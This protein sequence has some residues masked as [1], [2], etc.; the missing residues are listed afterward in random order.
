MAAG[1][2][3]PTSPAGPVGRAEAVADGNRPPPRGAPGQVVLKV[4]QL[5]LA[6]SAGWPLVNVR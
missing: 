6:K 5:T 3:C 2:T 4:N 1:T